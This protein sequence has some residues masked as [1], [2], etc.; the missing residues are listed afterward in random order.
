[1]STGDTAKRK[2]AVFDIDGTLIRWQLYHAVVS[3]L[4]KRGHLADNAEQVI[5][6]AR[7]TWKKRSHSESFREYEEVLVHTYLDA[8]KGL[9]TNDYL[10]A[11]GSVFE[12]H[13]DQV[14]TY[15]RDLVTSLKAK[16]YVLFAISGSQN[17]IVA[18]LATYYSFDD[19]K[20]ADFEQKDGYFTG[21]VNTPF[22]R[23]L[24]PLKELVTKHG[25][26]FEGSIGVGDSGSDISMLEAVSKPIAF[27]P[28]RGLF[29]TAKLRGWEVIIERKNVVYKLT[30]EG[31]NGQYLL[32]STN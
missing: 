8:L 25:L 2:F 19:Y 5:H 11:V 14:Y 22:G 24:E 26:T 9:K 4:A 3:E 1:M 32:A 28:N 16:N 20:G 10:T 27:N 30:Q 21:Q 7:M 17:E 29:E 6:N 15:T 18:K 31:N 23:K 12:E 13:K